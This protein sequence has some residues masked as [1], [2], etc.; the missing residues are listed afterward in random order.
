[1]R[2]LA[3]TANARRGVVGYHLTFAPV[4][5]AVVTV[6]ARRAGTSVRRWLLDTILAAAE[7]RPS[8]PPEEGAPS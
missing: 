1:M 6:A 2:C 3:D 5:Y 7:R 4:D 8:S